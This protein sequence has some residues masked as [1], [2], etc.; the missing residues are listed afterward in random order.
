MVVNPAFPART[1]AEFIA[2]AKANPGKPNMA[3]PSN[4][5]SGHVAG[6][7]L[8]MMAGV[9]LLHVSGRLGLTST[10]DDC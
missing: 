3:S 1:V 6:E 5:T 2:N 7:L 10:G 4:A 8:E 9:D